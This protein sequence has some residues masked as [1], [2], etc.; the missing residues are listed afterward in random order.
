MGQNRQVEHIINERAQNE[1][2]RH[3]FI[4][5]MLNSFQEEKWCCMLFELVNGGDLFTHLRTRGYLSN[6]GAKTYASEVILA[7]QYIHDWRI[8]YRDLKP[9]NILLDSKGHVRLSDFGLSKQLRHSNDRTFT[10]CGTAEYMAPEVV[11]ARG[12]G[13]PADFWS[14]GVLIFE[15]MSARTPFDA[16][17]PYQIYQKV[18]SGKVDYPRYFD[19]KVT[20]LL[21]QLLDPNRT[22]RLGAVG[23]GS[24]EVKRHQW[25]RVDWDEVLA[26]ELP[27][28]FEPRVS[29]PDDLMY[30]DKFEDV[31]YHELLIIPEKEMKWFSTFT[32]EAPANLFAKKKKKK[33]GDEDDEGDAA[34]SKKSKSRG[35][36][37]KK[38]STRQSSSRQSSRQ[39][40]RQSTGKSE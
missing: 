22:L 20:N 29:G 21:T 36:T 33:D 13:F 23:D 27:V 31:D 11:Q 7:L 15:M 14:F 39:K 35:N 32:P 28:A 4:V 8:V 16:E 6:D 40:T 5:R 12:H 38:G 24:E 3:P 19:A 9:E 18:L 37:V 25:F 17:N 2:L 1:K 30:F 10:V 34:A 26:M